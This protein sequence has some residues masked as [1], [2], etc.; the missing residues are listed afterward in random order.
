[1]PNHVTNIL[2]LSGPQSAID[3]FYK[4]LL[5]ENDEVDFERVLP[6]PEGEE[7]NWYNW[8]WDNWGTKWNAYDCIIDRE[9]NKIQFDTAWEYPRPV[10]EHLVKAHPKV[11][12][13]ILSVNEGGFP[14]LCILY[15]NGSKTLEKTIDYDEDKERFLRYFV[16]VKGYNPFD[17]E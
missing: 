8:K 13:K 11:S 14:I 1:M 3:K 12:V 7:N 10:I 4:H 6:M 17:E 16:K 5:D 9:N 2:K 15:T